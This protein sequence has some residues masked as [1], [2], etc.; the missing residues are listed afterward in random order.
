MTSAWDT[1]SLVDGKQN[2]TIG[3]QEVSAGLSK[4]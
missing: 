1:L 3:T 2:L 4:G